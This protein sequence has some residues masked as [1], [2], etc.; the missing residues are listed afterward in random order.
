MTNFPPDIKKGTIVASRTVEHLD[1][2]KESVVFRA[3]L[4]NTIRYALVD[5]D[6]SPSGFLKFQKPREGDSGYDLMVSSPTTLFAKEQVIVPTG[7]F[8]EIPSTYVGIIKERSSLAMQ[9]IY[10]HAGVIDSSYRG[11]IKVVVENCGDINYHFEPGD[12]VAQILFFPFGRFD[13]AQVQLE[14]LTQT[15]RGDKGFG[16]TGK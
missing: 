3:V 14:E 2:R 6:H 11:E 10:V 1:S 13:I 12:R 7:L 4:P 9:R 8:L 16:S 5:I 15:T